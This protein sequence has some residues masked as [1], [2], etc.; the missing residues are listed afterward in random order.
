ME[1][2]TKSVKKMCCLHE[3][4]FQKEQEKLPLTKREFENYFP[5]STFTIQ[6]IATNVYDKQCINFDVKVNVYG[7]GTTGQAEAVRMAIARCN[8]RSRSGKQSCPK[9][10]R[11]TNKRSKNGR[12]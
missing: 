6:S 3:F 4:M 11:I 2:F 9:T 12:A 8:V 7:G 1:L 10:R 5:T